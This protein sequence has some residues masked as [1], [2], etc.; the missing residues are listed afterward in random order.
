VIG[1]DGTDDD[2]INK[3]PVIQRLTKGIGWKDNGNSWPN[4]LFH[5]NLRENFDPTKGYTLF[6]SNAADY[7]GFVQGTTRDPNFQTVGDQIFRFEYMYLLKKRL[8]DDGTVLPQKLSIVPFHP[9]SGV[10]GSV[11]GF[12]DVEAIVVA[13]AVLDSKSREQ[14]NDFSLLVDSLPDAVDNFDIESQWM[15]QLLAPSYD[16]VAGIP[17]RVVPNIRVYQRYFYLNHK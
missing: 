17:E 11:D 8:L 5:K 14:V 1:Y 13:I 2:L 15:A 12:K 3:G 4:L 16:G 6:S 9:I 10:T 7:P